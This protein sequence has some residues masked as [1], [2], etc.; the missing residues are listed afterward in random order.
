MKKVMKEAVS[1]ELMSSVFKALRDHCPAPVVAT[2]LGGLSQTAHFSMLLRLMEA[3]DLECVKTTFFNLLRDDSVDPPLRA[4]LQ[5]LQQAY[6]L[7]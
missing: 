5:Q 3:G 6:N 7:G 4:T 2:V 1:P